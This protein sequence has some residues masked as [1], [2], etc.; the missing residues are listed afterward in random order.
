MAPVLTEPGNEAVTGLSGT[1]IATRVDV[2]L[3]NAAAHSTNVKALPT[4][5]R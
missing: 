3:V 1:E 4:A 2:V 5:P